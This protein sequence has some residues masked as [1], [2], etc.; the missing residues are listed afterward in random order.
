MLQFAVSFNG[1]DKIIPFQFATLNELN[2]ALLKD[3]IKESLSITEDFELYLYSDNFNGFYEI[4]P[5]NDLPIDKNKKLQVRIHKE[6]IEIVSDSGISSLPVVESQAEPNNE[7]QASG[8]LAIQVTS[9]LRTDLWEPGCV[10]VTM[11]EFSLKSRQE[12]EKAMI[13]YQSQLLTKKEEQKP[14]P[15]SFSLKKEIG[16]IL[17]PRLFRFSCYPTPEMISDACCQLISTFPCLA[18]VNKTRDRLGVHAWISRLSD[19][20]NEI[21]RVSKHPEVVANKRE[22]HKTVI[23]LVLFYHNVF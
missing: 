23:Y 6:N 1:R 18:N 7:A 15:A 22:F 4:D 8:S 14:H 20:L 5:L 21:R 12:L 17:G 13:N 10:T 11:E 2:L 19:K 3:T 9:S 16:E